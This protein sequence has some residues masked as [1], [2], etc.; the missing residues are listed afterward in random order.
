MSTIG[1]ENGITPKRSRGGIIPYCIENDLT[2][3][4]F[5]VDRKFQQYTD[6]GGGIKKHETSLSGS[7]REFHE[8]SGKAF[9]DCGEKD[10]DSSLFI[11][12]NNL[13][14]YFLPVSREK[15]GLSRK[16]FIPNDEISD[17]KWMSLDELCDILQDGR[18]RSM[19]RVI[20][21]CLRGIGDRQ[22]WIEFGGKLREC[23]L[24]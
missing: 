22:E 7:L 24:R 15:K 11:L 9:G 13:I 14:I 1:V 3:F 16:D 19:Y 17:I 12:S 10:M 21:R 20:K 18:D 2:Y 4:C 23:H 8:E 5:G 6:F